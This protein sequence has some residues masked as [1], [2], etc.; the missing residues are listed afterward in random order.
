[1]IQSQSELLEILRGY[2]PAALLMGLVELDLCTRLA[3]YPQGAT[4]EELAAFTGW[5]LRPLSALLAAAASLGLLTITEAGRYANTALSTNS[6]VAGGPQYIGPQ[7][8][9]QSDQSRGWLDLATG[10]S[11]G[12]TVLPNLQQ[13]VEGDPALRRLIMGLHGGAQKVLPA[14]TPRL[15]PYL[16]I[17][18]RLLDV[19]SGAGSFSLAW[20]EQFDRLEVT[21]LDHPGVIEI[22]LEVAHHSPARSRVKPWPTDYRQA[23]FGEAVYDMILFF[24]VLRTESPLV[25]Q[26]LLRKA[27]RALT[28]GGKV[29][30]FDTW[31]EDDRSGPSENVFQNLTLALMYEEGGLFTQTELAGW[32][33]QAGLELN[34]SWPLT[35]ARPMQLY[36]AGAANKESIQ[37]SIQ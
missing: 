9:S 14:L 35:G 21:L 23:D 25:I 11:E 27:A 7:A 3:G 34:E 33:L 8:R 10:I 18:R 31:L 28:P 1:M 4:P 32:L 2:Q 36:L 13:P 29:A 16:A 5:H 22:A 20:A 37:E 26:T 30:I 19:G 12:R 17:S 24:Q 15:A 6:L